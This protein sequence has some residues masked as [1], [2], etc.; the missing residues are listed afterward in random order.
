MLLGELHE[1][2]SDH[3]RDLEINPLLD[4]KSGNMDDIAVYTVTHALRGS[5][6]SAVD[7]SL[8]W[9][10]L[11]SPQLNS[12]LVRPLLNKCREMGSRA[13]IFCLLTNCTQF[14][15]EAEEDTARAGV[16]N[17]RAMTC[18]LL[19]CKFLKEFSPRELIDVLTFDF[20]PLKGHR[21]HANDVI[22]RSQRI[23]ALEVAIK[24]VCKK[25]LASPLV[26]QVLENIWKGNIVFYGASDKD[27]QLLPHKMRKAASTY[28]AREASIFK[29]SRLRVPRYRHWMQTISFAILLGL[30]IAVLIER[31]ITIMPLE[32]IM[33]VYA[34]GF[35]LEEVVGLNDTGSSLFL[36]NLWNSFDM[37]TL[38]FFI[39]FFV[40][41]IW[42]LLYWQ[43]TDMQYFAYDLLA[44]NTVF[45]TPRLFSALDHTRQFSQMLIAF[46]RMA[47]DLITSLIFILIFFAGFFLALSL[48][49]AR[50]LYTAPEVAF[51]LLQL[52][53]GFSPA[54]WALLPEINWIGK[55]LLITF[56]V[57]TNY[58]VVTIL[59]SV[60]STT[61]ASVIT[62]AHEEHQYLF[63]LNTI[64]A[65]KSDALFFYQ[66]PLNL[67]E[68]LLAP[69][70]LVMPRAR[71]IRLNRYFIK[72]L[73]FPMLAAIYMFERFYLRPRAFLPQDLLARTVSYDTM[74]GVSLGDGHQRS[75][76][77]AFFGR[78]RRESDAQHRNS[79][80]ILQQVF[81]R[82]QS[83]ALRSR[84]YGATRPGGLS[85]IDGRRTND[86]VT[87]L[88]ED[89][90]SPGAPTPSDGS[91]DQHR[92]ISYFDGGP[93]RRP[94]AQK[95]NTT[96]NL[97]T[98]QQ[99]STLAYTQKVRSRKLRLPSESGA[100]SDPEDLTVPSG[101]PRSVASQTALLSQ[102]ARRPTQDSFIDVEERAHEND[103][104]D[105]EMDEY[106]IQEESHDDSEHDANGK[107]S[108]ENTD[109][110]TTPE[111]VKN[112]KKFSV[113]Q[114]H[115]RSQS[116][117]T[118]KP[119]RAVV[120]SSSN[121]LWSRGSRGARAAGPPPSRSSTEN[122]SRSIPK[123]I[124]GPETK[125]VREV[126][127]DLDKYSSS[128]ATQ[129]ADHAGIEGDI[130]S[131]IVMNRVDGIE[132]AVKGG[133][134]RM[135]KLES[136]LYEL[137]REMKHSRKEQEQ[138]SNK[139]AG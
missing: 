50:N 29:L 41:R 137:I 103:S 51:K 91:P 99:P 71:W 94:T 46:Q 37:L 44:V 124:R 26:V 136:A 92:K 112:R 133:H 132:T 52:I 10:Q 98:R 138:H 6:S 59:V 64:L 118:I 15:K 109:I 134:A 43:G 28:D 116:E 42:G 70:A 78:R 108:G 40:L 88:P 96:A 31:S 9:E 75:I 69:L 19:A 8:T 54:A 123:S 56:M 72:F 22:A 30:V 66:A 65:V 20:W 32:I 77:A 63:A 115:K 83:S 80:E 33:I 101:S 84:G 7:T 5:V 105:D 68:W 58:L 81:D 82:T 86:W 21:E 121:G 25:F 67:I 4:G 11:K 85:K 73:H 125:R 131:R 111:N 129:L 120:Q 2:D 122:V 3:A 102:Q 130:L 39:A 126:S 53:F 60:L 135:E 36:S 79:S 24:G 61:F 114:A 128:L 74:R 18:E 47:Y 127:N 35:M 93:P 16:N 76:S 117:A 1:A 104:G 48:A 110:T 106:A 49:F 119:P 38:L 34:I 12:F 45:L 107:D 113:A 14:L 139:K 90:F 87:R 23:S 17:T 27:A 13:I 89:V 55:I 95:R 97:S 57:N 100:M 62:N